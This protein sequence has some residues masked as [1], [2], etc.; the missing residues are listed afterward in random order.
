MVSGYAIGFSDY[1]TYKAEWDKAIQSRAKII[2][3]CQL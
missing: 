1:A 3:D 2:K